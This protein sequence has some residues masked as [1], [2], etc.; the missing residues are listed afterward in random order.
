MDFFI[1]LLNEPSPKRRDFLVERA[2]NPAFLERAIASI[3]VA[4]QSI[5]EMVLVLSPDESVKFRQQ[6]ASRKKPLTT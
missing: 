1:F 3:R 2:I 4:I 5:I 6:R